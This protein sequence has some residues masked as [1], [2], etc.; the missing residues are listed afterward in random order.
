MVTQ[1]VDLNCDMGESFGPWHMGDDHSVLPYVSSVNVACGFHAGDPRTMSRTVETAKQLGVGVGAH[2]GFGDLVGFGRRDLALT[3]EEARTDVL[4]QIGALSGFCRRL[5]VPLQHVKPHGQ[6][7]NLAMVNR[8][9]ADAIVMG[10][11]DFDPDLLMVA[12]GGELA[13]AAEEHGLKVVY[14]VYAD[15]EYNPDGTLVP[16]KLAG[17]VITEPAR[18]VDRA[19]ELV[20]TGRVTAIDGTPLELKV[21]TICVHGDT[22]GVVQLIVRLREGFRKAG[23][24][25][26]PMR[27]I[28]SDPSVGKPTLERVA[29]VE[30]VEE[31]TDY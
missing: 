30:G 28:V 22:P 21:Q 7:N 3:P 9:L 20:R 4:Y 8:K 27:E 18:V 11:R 17:A 25:V 16:R 2:P 26:V 6:L 24:E 13:K 23:I 15:R 19:V 31:G 1:R 5:G 10:V 29:D 12:Y 14:E